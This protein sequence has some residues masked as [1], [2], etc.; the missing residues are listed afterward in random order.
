[1]TVLKEMPFRL[2]NL[3]NFLSLLQP[4]ILWCVVVTQ[5]QVFLNDIANLDPFQSG[6]R[7]ECGTEA[8]SGVLVDDPSWKPDREFNLAES[9]GPLS[10]F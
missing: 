3:N 5:L 1:M 4:V 2:H 6:F 8:V 9:T 7:L 10:S